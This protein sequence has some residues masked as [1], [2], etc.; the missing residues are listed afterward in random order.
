M[1]HFEEFMHQPTEEVKKLSQEIVRNEEVIETNTLPEGLLDNDVTLHHIH[2][3]YDMGWQ[4]WSSG[5]KFS[6]ST[7]S[8]NMDKK[9]ARQ[10]GI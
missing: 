8:W 1:N 10:H 6:S 2:A 4:I 9:G 3:S 7:G 5:I